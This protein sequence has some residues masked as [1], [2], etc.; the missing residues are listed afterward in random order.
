MPRMP[1]PHV[2]RSSS[3]SQPASLRMRL[4]M[5]GLMLTLSSAAPVMSLIFGASCGFPSDGTW[6]NLRSC[7]YP[8]PKLVEHGFPEVDGQSRRSIL[9]EL[10][11]VV[12]HQKFHGPFVLLQLEP[13]LLNGGHHGDVV[14]R[15]IASCELHL[16]IVLAAEAGLIE[17]GCA[18]QALQ[19]LGELQHRSTLSFD[20]DDTLRRAVRRN[21][22]I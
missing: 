14:G 7:G 17:N 2:R 21:P 16:E 11:E 6:L 19:V 9:R 5:P 1:Q 22:S 3:L 4:R 12:D 15:I 10:I 13:E 18:Q 8:G 20:G